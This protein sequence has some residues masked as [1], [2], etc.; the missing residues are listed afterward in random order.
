MKNFVIG[1][2][3]LFTNELKLELVKAETWQEAVF[4]HSQCPFDTSSTWN[5]IEEARAEAFELD[6]GFDILE[7]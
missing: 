7:I 6:G 5:T 1:V 2:F 4:K 3:S